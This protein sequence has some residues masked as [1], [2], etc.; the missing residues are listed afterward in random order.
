MTNNEKE[1]NEVFNIA[2]YLQ[3]IGSFSPQADFREMLEITNK[4]YDFIKQTDKQ[5]VI[6]NLSEIREHLYKI[7]NPFIKL[8][9]AKRSINEIATNW[10]NLFIEDEKILHNGIYYGWLEEQLDLKKYKFYNNIPFHF[11]IGLAA[12]KGHFDIEE[13]FLLKDAFNLLVKAEYYHKLLQIYGAKQ[14]QIEKAKSNNEFNGQIYSQITNIKYEVATYSKLSIISFYAFIE[15]FVNSVAHDYLKRNENTLGEND[16]EL[17]RG[18]KKKSYLT[19]KSKIELYQ[20]IIRKDKKA[21]FNTTDMNQIKEPFKSFFDNYEELRN[22]SVHFAPTKLK[23][24][25]RPDDWI[26]K[27]TQFSKISINV[28]LQFWKSC[29]ECTN[30][31]EYLGKLDYKKHHKIAID[32]LEKL[33]KMQFELLS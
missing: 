3:F 8:Y 12:H 16:I 15:S 7:A 29:Y 17:L 19:L 5:K 30:G 21:V 20:K 4:T 11:K 22:A 26:E 32:N 31:P 14:K 25:L 6:S 1:I 28:G 27:A 13:N 23:I 24:W 2:L 9:P 33:H 10:N 18:F